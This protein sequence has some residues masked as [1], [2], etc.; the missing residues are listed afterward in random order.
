MNTTPRRSTEIVE[1]MERHED[2]WDETAY[3]GWGTGYCGRLGRYVSQY[4]DG[5]FQGHVEPT[6]AAASEFV[7]EW[8]AQ[9]TDGS[10]A[11]K[12]G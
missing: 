11:T 6:E 4:K 12:E 5:S 2:D 8:A 9:Y 1:L 7:H 10:V 3:D